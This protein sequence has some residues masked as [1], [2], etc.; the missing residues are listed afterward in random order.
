MSNGIWS[1][2]MHKFRLKY[3]RLVNRYY[4]ESTGHSPFQDNGMSVVSVSVEV[5]GVVSDV[6]ISVVKFALLV[7]SVVVVIKLLSHRL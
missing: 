2:M 3:W 7:A 6:E 1:Y 4:S 5:N